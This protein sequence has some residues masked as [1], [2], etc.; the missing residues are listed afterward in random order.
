LK[1]VVGDAL[2][3][4]Q[5]EVAA[6]PSKATPREAAILEQSALLAALRSAQRDQVAISTISS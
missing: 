3:A 4:R 6:S 1:R 2:L 5:A